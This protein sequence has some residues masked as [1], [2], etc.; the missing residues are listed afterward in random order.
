MSKKIHPRRRV[1]AMNRENEALVI[2]EEGSDVESLDY[3]QCCWSVF[4]IINWI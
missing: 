1:T 4:M 2:I 3:Y